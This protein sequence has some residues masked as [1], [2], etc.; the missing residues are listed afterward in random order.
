MCYL[1]NFP[2]D[3]LPAL[4]DY[5]ANRFRVCTTDTIVKWKV[6]SDKVKISSKR[7]PLGQRQ[8]HKYTV[9]WIRAPTKKGQAMLH[10]KEYE[11]HAVDKTTQEE[12]IFTNP[13]LWHPYNNKVFVAC[14]LHGITKNSSRKVP[15]I[16]II[17]EYNQDARA[18]FLAYIHR[19]HVCKKTVQL[20]QT[21]FENIW[22]MLRRKG[23]SLN[24][25]YVQLPKERTTMEKILIEEL[26]FQDLTVGDEDRFKTALFGTSISRRT[27]V[28]YL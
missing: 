9:V 10:N 5:T 14:G 15:A 22:I 17:L 11:S 6:D 2:K 27:I 26:G 25:A 21:L 13:K 8:V 7:G 23:M 1:K 16:M 3:V 19:I 12:V 18:V 4:Y 24:K 20:A 28:K